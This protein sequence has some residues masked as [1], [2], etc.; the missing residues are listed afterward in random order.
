M[1]S[2]T[3]LLLASLT[4]PETVLTRSLEELD[5]LLRVA[6]A[7]SL[8][9]RLYHLFAGV[10]ALE[11]LDQRVRRH[12]SGAYTVAKR[13]QEIA[14][15]EVSEIHRA[16]NPEHIPL[17]L[18]KGAAYVMADLPSA[19]GRL[20]ADVDILVPRSRLKETEQSLF[21]FG[22]VAHGLDAYDQKY[23]RQ[24]MHELPPLTHLKRKSV[25]DVH[26]SILPITT[27]LKPDARKLI[28]SAI[29]VK[30]YQ[31]MYVLSPA[32]MILHSATHLFHNGELEHGLRD[33]ADLDDLLR[34]FGAEPTFWSK[35]TDRAFE[36]DLAL[37]LFYGL[38]YTSYFLNTPV[39]QEAIRSLEPVAPPAP[40]LS[41][42]DALFKRGLAP[43]HWRCDGSLSGGARWLLYLRSHYLRM[44]LNLLVPH[45]IR[46]ALTKRAHANAQA[47][48]PGDD[49]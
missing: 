32:D 33:L 19:R 7:S 29:P 9:A 22:W 30:G 8:E 17:I 49:A 11:K 39:P 13:Q 41:I 47:A 28:D 34:H 16:L 1:N 46:K 44:P 36:M 35:L 25:L 45:L 38:R 4:R 5:L 42:L 23:Y 40:R 3:D 6:R 24:W 20:F 31:G 48:L 21:T 43:H 15:W 27:R 2:A 26:H 14:R 12:L 18:L 10:G 37:P